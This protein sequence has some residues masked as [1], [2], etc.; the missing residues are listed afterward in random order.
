MDKKGS[1]RKMKKIRFKSLKKTV[2]PI[3]E[4]G[5]PWWGSNGPEDIKS[6]ED[7][8]KKAIEV[9]VNLFH[10]GVQYGGGHQEEWVGNAIKDCREDMVISAQSWMANL[11]PDKLNLYF[12]Q[13]LEN[14]QTDYADIYNLQFA[15]LDFPISK[16]MEAVEKLRS[17]G[18]IT[19]VSVSNFPMTSLEKAIKYG[20]IDIMQIPYSLLWRQHEKDLFPFCKEHGIEIIASTALAQGLLGGKVRLDK[21]YN[22]GERKFIMAGDYKAESLYIVEKLRAIATEVGISLPKLSLKWLLAK[23]EISAALISARTP[24]EISEDIEAEDLVVSQEILDR[25]T[26][27]SDELADMIPVYPDLYGNWKTFYKIRPQVE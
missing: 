22:E 21:V 16:T 15:N 18:K 17:E 23:P 8:Y 27:V 10:A 2:S 20:K 13:S 7:V 11:E 3:G 1:N 12:K 9:G 19:A 25:M 4:G 24:E 26:V 14:M 5:N 6:V